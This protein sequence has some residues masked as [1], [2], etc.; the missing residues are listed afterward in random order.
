MKEGMS[1]ELSSQ[2]QGYYEI[3]QEHIE[4]FILMNNSKN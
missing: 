4:K 3:I 2:K 1:D